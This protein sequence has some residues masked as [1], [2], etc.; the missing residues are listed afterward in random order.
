MPPGY[1]TRHAGDYKCVDCL[2]DI[3]IAE[4]VT[5]PQRA[6]LANYLMGGD[7]VCLEHAKKRLRETL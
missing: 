2:R 6:K 4:D 5:D 7:A 1:E 3:I